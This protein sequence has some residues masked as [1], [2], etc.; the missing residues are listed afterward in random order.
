MP[1]GTPSREEPHQ[2]QGPIRGRAKDYLCPQTGF[3]RPRSDSP[4]TASSPSHGMRLG[5][6]SEGTQRHVSQ[7][8]FQALGEGSHMVRSW[9]HLLQSPQNGL[10]L[11]HQQEDAKAGEGRPSPQSS[12]KDPS[13]AMVRAAAQEIPGRRVGTPSGHQEERGAGGIP[14]QPLGFETCLDTHIHFFPTRHFSHQGRGTLGWAQRPCRKEAS[15]GTE[16]AVMGGQPQA[17]GGGWFQLE[18]F[19]NTKLEERM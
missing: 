9:A 7:S 15:S 4:R 19:Y 10:K 18:N 12:C 16:K 8:E 13:P 17:W 2:T 14:G 3:P 6:A 11:R 5:R 1:P